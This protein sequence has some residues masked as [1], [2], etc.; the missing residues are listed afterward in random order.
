MLEAIETHRLATSSRS[1][2]ICAS[3]SASLGA[4]MA[5]PCGDRHHSSASPR[6]AFR[7]LRTSSSRVHGHRA[8]TASRPHELSVVAKYTHPTGPRLSESPHCS[9]LRGA[10][11]GAA[12]S[13]GRLRPGRRAPTHQDWR[14]GAPATFEAGL[15]H[16]ENVEDLADLAREGRRRERLLEELHLGIEHATVGDGVIRVAGHEQHLRVGAADGE[17]LG[18]VPTAHL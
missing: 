9:L 5:G 15:L 11:M 4:L 12:V 8:L 16:T 10:H 18:Q 1:A 14:I 6:V 2:L 7:D 17:L 3:V 13:V